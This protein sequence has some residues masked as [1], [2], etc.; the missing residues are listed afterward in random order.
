VRVEPA[1]FG[2]EFESGGPIVQPM[3]SPLNGV[4]ENTLMYIIIL[5]GSGEREDKYFDTEV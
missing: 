5:D 2:I 4:Y 1:K 3:Q